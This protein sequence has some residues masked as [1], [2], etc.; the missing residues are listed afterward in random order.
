MD[1]FVLEFNRLPL[2]SV[3]WLIVGIGRQWIVSLGRSAISYI[4]REVIQKSIVIKVC[5]GGRR[6][7]HL[8]PKERN[9]VLFNTV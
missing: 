6:N 7:F 9:V 8:G 5:F 2:I 1:G 3:S 4:T